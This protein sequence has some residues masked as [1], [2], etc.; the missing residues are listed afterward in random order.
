L[1]NRAQAEAKAEIDELKKKIEECERK[2]EESANRWKSCLDDWSLREEEFKEFNTQLSSE[3]ENLKQQLS[4]NIAALSSSIIEI[5]EKEN[6]PSRTQ[7][8]ASSE[9]DFR[10]TTPPRN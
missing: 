2:E 8:I 4:L 10:G 5:R 6:A 3:T 1:K 7:C 9:N